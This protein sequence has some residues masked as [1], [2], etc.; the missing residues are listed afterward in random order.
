MKE[1]SYCVRTYNYEDRV[2][3]IEFLESNGFSYDEDRVID[4]QDV[5]D[6]TLPLIINLKKKRFF[7]VGNVTCAAA[8]A[9]SGCIISDKE[10]Y[11]HF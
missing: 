11:S 9:S 4:R 1:E 6:S 10:F 3:L 7:R 8:M 5:L 2:K